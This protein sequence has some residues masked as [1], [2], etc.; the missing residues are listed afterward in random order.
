[1]KNFKVVSVGWG[2]MNAINYM[3]DSGLTGAEFI[4]CSVDKYGLQMS[5]ADRKVWLRKIQYGLDDGSPSRSE[6]AAIE[7]REEILSALSRADA[8]IIVAGLGGCDGTGASPITVQYAKELGALTVAVVSL[9][10]KFEGVRRTTRAEDALKKLSEQA[11][12]VIKIRND[13]ILQVVDKNT[14]MTKAFTCIDE[15]MCHA[16]RSLINIFQG[17]FRIDDITKIKFSAAMLNVCLKFEGYKVFSLRYV[18][19]AKLT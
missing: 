11:D 10:Y 16:V 14:S 1:M 4:S 6:Q 8:V 3:I 15:I 9:P 19:L 2:G 13:K 17:A 7:S 18:K 5:K 12:A